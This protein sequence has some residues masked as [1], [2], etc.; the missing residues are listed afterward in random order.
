MCFVSREYDK[1]RIIILYTV[2]VETLP[3]PFFPEVQ[4]LVAEIP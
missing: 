2:K 4:P 1:T 3:F